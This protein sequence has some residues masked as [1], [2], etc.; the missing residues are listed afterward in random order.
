[1]KCKEMKGLIRALN[2]Q[3]RERDVRLAKAHDR[4][5]CLEHSVKGERLYPFNLLEIV[6]RPR[7]ADYLLRYEMDDSCKIDLRVIGNEQCPTVG[8]YRTIRLSALDLLKEDKK[9]FIKRMGEIMAEE[10]LALGVPR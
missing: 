9:D 1:M 10:I 7:R 4:I 3:L 5:D 2:H 8:N 6:V